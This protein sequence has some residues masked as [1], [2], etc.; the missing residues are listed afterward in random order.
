MATAVLSATELTIRYGP[1][2][3]L[4]RA[5]LSINENDRVGLVGRN[6]T[7]KST[8]LRVAAGEL[9]PDSGAVTRKRE[10]VT[11]YLPQ[12]FAV[13][14]ALTVHDNIMAGAQRVLEMIAEYERLPGD[15]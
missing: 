9:E 11:G 15:S 3:V 10:L 4:D 5:T 1:H 13:N 14:E 7:G 2:T 12:A 6:G 8:F